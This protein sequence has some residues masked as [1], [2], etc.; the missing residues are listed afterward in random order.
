M[1]LIFTS[2][3]L[4]SL[5]FVSCTKNKEGCIPKPIAEE[6]PSMIAFCTANNINYTEDASGILY[7]IIN[8]G[9][10][11][12]PT[13]NSK[14]FIYYQG[15]LLNGTQFDAQADPTKTGWYLNTLIDGW[16]KGLP[17]ISKG[18][19]IK[20]VIPSSLAYGCTGS[21]VI[22]ANSPLYFDITLTEVLP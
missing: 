9:S 6:K 19:R 14:I 21:G 16:Q 13:I 3:L 8:P 22:P 12:T 10:G 1:K 7:E 4:C 15:T 11:I 20:L 5:I 2:L 18:G 17:L